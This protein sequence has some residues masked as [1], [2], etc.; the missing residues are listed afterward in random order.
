MN[1]PPPNWYPDPKGEAELRYWDGSQWT[2]HT[3]SGAAAA[4][5]PAAP[6]PSVAPPAQAPPPSG[7]PAGAAPQQAYAPAP[8][9]GAPAGPTPG[10]AP[11]SGGGGSR[12]P[13]I[14][15]AAVLGVIALVVIGVLALGGGDDGGGEEGKVEDVVKKSITEK[16]PAGCEELVTTNFVQKSTGETGSAA[17]SECKSERQKSALSDDVEVSDTKVDGDRATATATLGS[18]PLK[19]EKLELTLVK[20]GGDWKV[21]DLDRPSQAD[22][23]AA[24]RTIITTVLNFGSSEGDKACEYLSFSKLQSLGGPSGCKSQFG[25]AVSAN[26]LPEDAKVTGK[27]AT[28]TVRETK[29]DAVIDFTLVRELGTWKIADFKKRS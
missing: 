14:I 20:Q 11:S 25:S 4:A 21:D 24:E 5:Q 10:A 7:P 3:H 19:D 18:G 15:G 8:G 6:P 9:A 12:L 29:Q 16:D 27:T 26:Y 22:P 23:D 2:E 17:V 28:L 1:Q 13:L